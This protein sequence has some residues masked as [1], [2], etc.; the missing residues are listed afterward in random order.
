LSKSKSDASSSV[1][2]RS[3][4]GDAVF[5]VRFGSKLNDGKESLESLLLLL[6]VSK[7]K[8]VYLL[9]GFARTER[10][11]SRRSSSLSSLDSNDS[12]R[13]LATRF[14]GNDT[15]HSNG[16][17]EHDDEEEE[18]DDDDDESSE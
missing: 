16:R 2:S 6:L 3:W 8:R 15:R 12:K 18:V 7:K 9:T 11:G 17:L 5:A 14:T 1:E 4:F 13:L 10:L